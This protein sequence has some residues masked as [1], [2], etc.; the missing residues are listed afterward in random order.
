MKGYLTRKRF[1]KMR[2]IL[3]NGFK[4]VFI[5][6]IVLLLGTIGG[7]DQGNFEFMDIIR[8]IAMASGLMACGVVGIGAVS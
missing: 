2:K 4:V 5:G 7:A 3:R 1:K 8:N 6:G